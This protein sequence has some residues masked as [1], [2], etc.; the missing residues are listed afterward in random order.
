MPIEDSRNKL[1]TMKMKRYL[2]LWN[3]G[4]ISFSSS[5]EI[6]QSAH[7]DIIRIINS[8]LRDFASIASENA[9]RKPAIGAFILSSTQPN[10]LS[11]HKKSLYVMLDRVAKLPNF[12]QSNNVLLLSLGYWVI[13]RAVLTGR[14]SIWTAY[15]G[16]LVFWWGL[17][18]QNRRW[19]S[20][21]PCECSSQ[22]IQ[23]GVCKPGTCKRKPDG[24]IFQ[25]FSTY[26]AS[27]GPSCSNSRAFPA[28]QQGRSQLKWCLKASRYVYLKSTC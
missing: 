28:F 3:F 11:K 17:R 13:F 12:A 24:G 8:C 1:H 23:T 2:Y 22:N 16:D 6:E 5:S 9:L 27:R 10:R 15:W 25:T 7:L 26:C 19:R 20:W 18:S 14:Q 21:K 4:I